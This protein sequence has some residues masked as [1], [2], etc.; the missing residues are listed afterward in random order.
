MTCNSNKC[1]AFVVYPYWN[2][3]LKGKKP[4][5][6]LSGVSIYKFHGFCNHTFWKSK[7]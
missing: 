2:I 7:I 4:Q 1:Q 3:F 6:I 5:N